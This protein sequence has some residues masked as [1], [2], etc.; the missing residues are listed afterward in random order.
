MYSLRSEF[1]ASIEGDVGVRRTVNPYRIGS[2]GL[3]TDNLMKQDVVLRQT[4]GEKPI[5]LTKLVCLVP[6]LLVVRCNYRT[7]LAIVF[8]QLK[9]ARAKRS[10]N[11]R[12][13]VCFPLRE[14]ELYK[15]CGVNLRP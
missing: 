10:Y 6:P 13:A 11:E 4:R 14:R 5:T 1:S 8:M 2:Q 12:R 7:I 9:G 15:I 3:A